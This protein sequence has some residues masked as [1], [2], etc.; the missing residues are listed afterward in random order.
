MCFCENQS[1]A[2]QINEIQSKEL[3]SLNS[4]KIFGYLAISSCNSNAM[5]VKSRRHMHSP[6]LRVAY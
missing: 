5:Q 3:F 6:G 2:K 4:M 1:L